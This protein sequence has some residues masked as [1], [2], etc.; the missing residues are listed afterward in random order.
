M[1]LPELIYSF[2]DAGVASIAIGPRRE[3]T[4]IVGLDDPNYP[5]HHRVYIRFGGISN[6]SEVALFFERVPRPVTKDAYLARIDS[7]D[8]DPQEQSRHHNLVFR[9]ELDMV[10]QLRI[11]CRNITLD[12]IDD[13]FT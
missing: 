9:L 13:P 7:L 12:S 8:Y 5:P 11:R 3:A 2:H 4:L 10:G 1:T 6:F